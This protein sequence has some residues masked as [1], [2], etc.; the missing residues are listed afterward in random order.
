MRLRPR[1]VPAGLIAA[2]ALAAACWA[3][4]A[5]A[6]PPGQAALVK[7]VVDGDTLGVEYRGAYHLVRLVGVDTPETSHSKSLERAA[8][9][10]GR[11]TE[12]EAGLGAAA[13]QAAG[14]LVR[15]GEV[16]RLAW[17]SRQPRRDKYGRLLAYVWLADGRMLNRELVAGGWARAMRRFDYD[18]KAEFVALEDQARRLGS[19]LWSRGGP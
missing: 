5:W 7:K 8:A 19:G 9:R 2:L 14:E 16:V 12:S 4:A 6:A 11:S 3:A 13:R 1:R 17:D 15:R 10:K 18:R